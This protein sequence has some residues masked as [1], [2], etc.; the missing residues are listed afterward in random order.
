MSVEIIKKK[1]ESDFNQYGIDINGLDRNGYNING[2]DVNGVNRNGYNINSV[3]VNGLDKNGL[4]INGI[5]GTKKIYPK[6]I[7]IIKKMIMVFCM[8]SMDLIQMDLIKMVITYM[9]SIKMD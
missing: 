4:N 3:D 7:L 1:K 9:A 2:V 5:K 8:T 6:K